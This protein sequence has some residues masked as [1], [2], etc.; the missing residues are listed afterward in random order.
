MKSR[1][2]KSQRR[3]EKEKKREDQRRERVR[4][5]KIQVREKVGKSRNTL[6]FSM[7]CDSG[8]SKGRLAK[9]ADAEQSG[10]MRD[11]KLHS[12]VARN[13]CRSQY[14]KNTSASEHFLEV[15]MMK[16]CT[17]LWHE[18]NFEVKRAKTAKFGALFDVRCCFPWQAQG[19]LHVAKTEQKRE[20]FVAF[21]ATTTST[22]HYTTLHYTQLHYATLHFSTQPYTTL[23]GHYPKYNYNYN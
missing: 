18:A 10:Q 3:E 12:V 7:I 5:K 1:D 23:P 14:V 2:G 13:T 4:R 9:A 16:K 8:G 15:E 19:I 6:F 17:P 21:S 22:L 20:D 11:E